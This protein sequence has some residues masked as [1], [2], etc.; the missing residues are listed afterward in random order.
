MERRVLALFGQL[1][2]QPEAG[3][4]A[5]IE[6]L[7]DVDEA[8]RARLRSLLAAESLNLLQTGGAVDVAADDAPPDR[9][10]AYRIIERIGRGGMGAVYRGE[11]DVGDFHHVVAIKVVRQG[12]LSD[13]LAARFRQERQTLAQLSHPNIARLFDGGET[14]GGSPYIVME[15]IEGEPLADWVARTGPGDAARRALF[16]SVCRAVAFAHRNLIVHRDITPNNILVTADG[17]PKL[18]DF[19]IARP[20][21]E[22]EAPEG[23]AAL[24]LSMTPG[25][26]APERMTS[27]TVSTAADIYSLG[28]LLDWLVPGKGDERA[29]IIARGTAPDPLERYSTADALAD[30]VAAWGAGRP[31]SA[32]GQDRAYVIRKFVQRNRAGVAVAAL[33]G[34]FLLGA[35]VSVL[36]ANHREQKARE[37]AEARFE[38]TRAIAKAMLF[39]AFDAVS[40]V[41][42][43]TEARQTLAETGLRYIEALAKGAEGR[44]D[45]SREA[46]LGFL[47]LA[48]VVGGGQAGQL[49]RY[50]DANALLARSEAILRPL[51]QSEP[52]EPATTI[53]YGKLLV[54]QAGTNLY[55]NNQT[56]LG[57]K[58][59]EQA[60]AL[61][62]PLATGSV[63][64]A[65]QYALALQAVGDSYGWN[66]DYPRAL[67]HHARAEQFIA[68]LSGPIREAVPVR[69]VRA[70]NLRLLGESYH[71]LRKPGE[72]KATLEQA[73][74]LN[75]SL[76]AAAPDDPIL[77][78]KL[79]SALWYSAV[80][81]RSNERNEAARGAIDEAVARANE[82]AGRDPRDA[83]ALHLVALT[84]EV[85]AQVLGDLGRFADS[86]AA[87]DLV[88]AAHRKLVAL[89]GR[90]PGALRSMAASMRTIGGNHYNGRDYAGAC[91]LWRDTLAIYSDLDRRGALTEIDRKGGMAEMAD[92]TARAC[93]NGGPRAGLGTEPI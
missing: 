39:D 72:A 89:G 69:I 68:G 66:D 73:V 81:H 52:N 13:E 53:A 33:T 15:Y 10:G 90:A 58:Q 35:L 75:R 55:S 21:E 43:S 7:P 5:W 16:I 78:R 23:R 45:I 59:A 36:I 64:A 70:G 47:R 87:G 12:L 54:E 91:A 56:D 65:Q 11:R 86:Y 29:A 74:A 17:A 50:D 38:Q 4:E 27:A 30:D 71:K 8:V 62:K 14:E 37:A 34:L 6:H 40:K 46:G 84:G 32:V 83:G 1:L 2:D 41:S 88:L 61:L 3:R 9:I 57:R 80:V 28:R 48:Q 49:G 25:Y 19:G 60:V 18:I 42:G 85:Q 67:G 63:E 31:V 79:I 20:P 22:S 44:S 77:S 26:A 76:L 92:Y 24:N 82:R 93:D 51:H